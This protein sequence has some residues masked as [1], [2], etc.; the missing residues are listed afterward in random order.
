MEKLTAIPEVDS[1]L[2]DWIHD[3]LCN[4]S[5]SVIINGTKS[6]SLPVTSGVPQ[7]SVLGPVLFLVY[8]NDLPS[9]VDCSV[10]LFAD[11]TLMYQVVNNT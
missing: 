4:R 9:Q 10:G 3:F 7:E 5:Q 6:S 11:D 1:Y 8:I 2:L